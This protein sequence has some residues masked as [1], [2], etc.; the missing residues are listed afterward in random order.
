VGLTLIT[1]P[2]NAGKVALLLRRYLEALNDEPFLIVPNRSDVERVE[3]DLLELQPALLAGS[4]GTFDDLF[5]RIARRG[6]DT[7]PVAG[8]AQRTLIVRRALAGQSLNG[9][10]R[11][12]RF[13]GFADALLTAVAELESGMLDPNDLE[14][15]LATLYAAYRAELDRLN[16]WDRDLLRRHAAE[17][18]ANEL[19]SWSGE[20]V[21]AY[22]FEDLTGAEWA[23]LQALAGRTD[24][25]VSM[26]YEPGRPAFASLARTMEDLT[27]LAD[28]RI[29]ELPPSFEQVA[30][31]ALAHLERALFSERS[32]A[33]APPIEGALRFFEAAGTRGVL[34]LVGEELLALIRGGTAPEEIGIVCPTLDR[35]QAPLETALGTLGVPY[36]LESYVRLDK[37]AYGQA[38][39]NLLRFAWLGGGRTELYAFLRSPYS[40]LSRQN[41]DFLEGRLR[42][43][44]VNE[45]DRVEE[46]T[47]RLRDGQPLPPLEALR[48]A[49]TPLDAVAG[50]AASMLRAAYGLE[51]PPVGEVS[52]QDVRA[53]ESVMRLL[54]ELRGWSD[55]E[56]SL[57]TEELVAALERAEVRRASAA[58]PGRVAVLDLLRARTRRFE[59]VFVLG[60]EEGRLPRRGHESPFLADDARRELDERSHARL[61]RPDQVARDRYL[62]YT[63]CTRATSRVYLAREAAGDDG[64]PRSPSPFWDEVVALFPAEDVQRWTRRRP[65]SQLTWPLEAAPTE[66]ERLRAVALR[67]PD[68]RA[69]AEAIAAANDWERR[70]SRALHA[71]ERQTRLTHPRVLAELSAKTTF[72]VTELERFVDCSSMWFFDR[73][74]D[75]KTM[76]REVDARMRG[77]IAHQTLYRFFSG[78]P[79]ELGIERVGADQLDAA[80]A[81]LRRCLDE[82]VDGVRMELTELQQREL[83]HG[84]WRDLE[85]FVREDAA[86]ESPLVPRRFEVSFGMERSAAELQRGL[87][88]A[89]GVT[90]SGKIDRIDVDPYSTRGIVQDYKAGKRGHSAAQIESEKKLQIPLY[91][92]VLRD[93]VGIEPLGGLYRPLSGERKPRG[94]LRAE[95]QDDGVPG[96]SSKDYLDEEAFW[97]QVE[98]SRE[99][100]VGIVERVR[101]GDIRHDPKS[102]DCPTW[103]ELWPM[104]RVKRA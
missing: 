72:N 9:L 41:V 17:R 68:D 39:L 19:D 90:L 28:G 27:S 91:M 46:E 7:R 21:F 89:D 76:D 64:S 2:A 69:A 25:T 103:C 38:L 99:L 18:V 34:E 45:P 8:D 62:F 33:D 47:I 95:A 11:S 73:M 48:S 75:P 36:A 86:A 60:L 50:L 5:N 16:L 97:N 53:H 29:E 10:G 102:G 49:P 15:E 78:L 74:I 32:P 57:S 4:I 12:A 26:P 85:A 59:V 6:A 101:S 94:L 96:Y 81:Y 20:P 66:R 24:V 104:C 43:R 84:L 88:L 30:A 1:G 67:A 80:L 77:S 70:L 82:A 44:A 87:E 40:G 61:S 58:E 71:F 65:L 92:L 98:S 31:P 37:T 54:G 23:L 56:G 63:A 22:G 55:L 14:G 93:L 13:G 51:A 79:K 52:R 35:W 3:R 42:G 83:R 100:A